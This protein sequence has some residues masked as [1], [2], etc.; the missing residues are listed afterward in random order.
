VRDKAEK[1][2]YFLEITDKKGFKKRICLFDIEEIEIVQGTK[3]N[4]HITSQGAYS[5]DFL[6]VLAR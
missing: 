6:N 1:G 4:I 5:Y 2:E 3:F